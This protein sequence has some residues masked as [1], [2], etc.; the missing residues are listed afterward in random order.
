MN[1]K[2]VM[3]ESFHVFIVLISAIV[4][5]LGVMW[6]ITPAGLYSSGITGFGQIISDIIILCTDGKVK[7][8]LGVF[9]FLFNIPLFIIGYRKVSI[10]FAIYSLL[11]VIVQSLF[12]MGWI[13]EYTFG[14][15]ALENQLLFALIGGLVTG[16]ANAVALRF[17]TST[18]GLDI[19]AQALSIEK[20]ISI[21]TFTMIFNCLIALVGG[22]VI[23]N[24]WEISMYTFIRIIISS[25]VIDKIHTAY[26]F[27][28]L[29]IISDHVEDISQRIMSELKR[30]VTLMSVEGAYTHAQKRDAFVILT[31]YELARAKRICMEADPNV[32]VIIAP[33][34]GTIGRFVRKTIM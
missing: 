33:A 12:M 6:F 24:A 10:R 29:D 4:Y 20:G 26:N 19:I 22:G 34:K 3:E 17:G 18:G 30:G 27:V 11:S 5:S 21:G 14:I 32:F 8:P 7:I 9:T 28:R 31:S 16:L 1:K 23:A 25:I 2:V 15:D 13:P